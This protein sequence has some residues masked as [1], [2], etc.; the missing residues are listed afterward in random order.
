[1]KSDTGAGNERKIAG[2]LTDEITSKKNKGL[3]SQIHGTV[4]LLLM[5]MRIR[6]YKLQNLSNPMFFESQQAAILYN[7][8]KIGVMGIL[9]P[10]VLA[11]FGWMHPVA[12]FELDLEPLEKIFFKD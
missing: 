4:D 9:H 5:K 10:L 1:M 7:G 6:D 2:L 3:F 12:V 8:E 11:N